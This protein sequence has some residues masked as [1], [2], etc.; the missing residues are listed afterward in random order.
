MKHNKSIYRIFVKKI[1]DLKEKHY[2]QLIKALLDRVSE[3]QITQLIFILRN[4][5]K[6]LCYYELINCFK[7]VNNITEG[8]EQCICGVN[9]KNIYNIYNVENRNDFHI[10]GSVCIE[11]WY[12]KS[13]KF[14]EK[15]DIC[16][17][18]SNDKYCFFCHRKT[19]NQRCLNCESREHIKELF[20]LWKS[21]TIQNNNNL[22]EITTFFK[23]MSI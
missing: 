8:H 21:Q 19:T 3:N 14:Q 7:R 4:G 22:N 13:D 11:N 15:R 23:R 17:I 6:Q 1:K 2:K 20:N 9:I 12:N 18:N 10:I 5:D 16:R